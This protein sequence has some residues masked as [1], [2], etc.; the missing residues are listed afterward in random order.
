MVFWFTI[1]LLNIR[2]GGNAQCHILTPSI[3]GN[4]THILHRTKRSARYYARAESEA[5]S[6]LARPLK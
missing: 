6:L 5:D 3:C 4:C 1:E 2:A